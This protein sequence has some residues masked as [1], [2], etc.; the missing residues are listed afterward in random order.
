[1]R[2]VRFRSTSKKPY[3][4]KIEQAENHQPLIEKVFQLA[5]EIRA[6]RPD[7]QARLV[8]MG[9]NVVLV[10]VKGEIVGHLSLSDARRYREKFL[11]LGFCKEEV[12]CFAN[13]S[14]FSIDGQRVYEICLDL[15]IKE[16]SVETLQ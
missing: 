15:D 5:S 1:M 4:L 16:M 3:P 11:Q 13:I 7:F 10:K 9:G 2:T 14:H 12:E 8:Y 6:Y